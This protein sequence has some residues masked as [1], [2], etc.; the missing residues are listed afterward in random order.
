MQEQALNFYI[1]LGYLLG[2]VAFVIGL[3]FLS[4]PDTARKGNILASIGM[5]IA[6]IAALL[7]PLSSGSNNYLWI[8]GGV[9][10]GS[11]IGW[12]AARRIQMTAMPQMV[13]MFNGLGGACAVV[14]AMVEGIQYYNGARTLDTGQL[15]HCIVHLIHWRGCLYG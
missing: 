10:V 15:S 11:I 7:A 1:N 5:G 14:L 3:R 4:S 9:V 6:I 12:I 13:S 2:A 8:L